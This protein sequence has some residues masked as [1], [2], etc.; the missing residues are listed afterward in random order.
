VTTFREFFKQ[1]HGFDFPTRGGEEMQTV[2][3]RMAETMADWMDELAKRASAP[4]GD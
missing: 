1:K 3:H 2:L 4:P